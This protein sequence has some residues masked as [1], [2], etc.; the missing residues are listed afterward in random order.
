MAPIKKGIDNTI[1]M[2]KPYFTNISRQTRKTIAAKNTHQNIMIISFPAP[3]VTFFPGAFFLVK[4]LC[5]Q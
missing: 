4:G 5:V 2:Y 3:K 1:A